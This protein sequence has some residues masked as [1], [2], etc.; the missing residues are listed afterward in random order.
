MFHEADAVILN[1]TDLLPYAGVS[2][3]EL[4]QN[5][6]EVNP[7]APIFPVSCRTGDG[8]GE[9]I[10]WLRMQSAEEKGKR[11]LRGVMAA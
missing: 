8:F 2:L 9:W 5:V 10:K 1:K 3:E 6:R 11:A 7:W 4:K